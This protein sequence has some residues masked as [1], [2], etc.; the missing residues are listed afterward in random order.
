[1]RHEKHIAL[2]A[3]TY[4]TPILSMKNNINSINSAMFHVSVGRNL[5]IFHSLFVCFLFLHVMFKK[6]KLISYSQFTIMSIVNSYSKYAGVGKLRPKGQ[7]RLVW[8]FNPAGQT[9][10]NHINSLYY[11]YISGN[12]KRCK[13]KMK[14]LSSTLSLP[15]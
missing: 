2:V 3:S 8:S 14:Q 1:M 4:S 15:L 6:N 5:L 13:K 10:P 7:M 9:C 11:R 12:Q